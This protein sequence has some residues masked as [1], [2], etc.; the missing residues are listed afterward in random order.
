MADRHFVDDRDHRER[1]FIDRARD[2]VRS[3]V[4]DEEAERR[5][6]VDE[7]GRPGSY[8]YGWASPRERSMSPPPA[9]GWR[10]EASAP[11]SIDDGRVEYDRSGAAYRG[12]NEPNYG[13]RPSYGY[14]YGEWATPALGRE[15]RGPAETR[16]YYEDPRGRLYEFEHQREPSFAGRGPKGYRRSDERIREDVCDRLGD[17]PR[18]DATDIDV[19]VKDG[20]VILAGTVRSREEK[21]RSEDMAETISGVRDIQNNLRVARP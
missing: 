11:W 3:W 19:T 7:R 2:E 10:G 13:Y 16:G 6:R 17:D 12:W 4:G 18:V 1:G 5:R 15:G 8:D 20:E 21:R 14:G 9:R